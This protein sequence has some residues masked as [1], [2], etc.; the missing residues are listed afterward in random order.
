MLSRPERR[1]FLGLFGYRRFLPIDLIGVMCGVESFRRFPPF[2]EGSAL[3][4]RK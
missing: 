3:T 4:L 1:S 2:I